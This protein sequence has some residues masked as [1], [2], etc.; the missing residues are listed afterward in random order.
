MRTSYLRYT[1]SFGVA[2]KLFALISILIWNFFFNSHNLPYA[3]QI[4]RTRPTFDQA[5]DC[6][7]VDLLL[8]VNGWEDFCNGN[9]AVLWYCNYKT[10]LG[11]WM[12]RSVTIFQM[13][14]IRRKY[15]YWTVWLHCRGTG[16]CIVQS[17][18]SRQIDKFNKTRKAYKLFWE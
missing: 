8:N 7:D 11:H 13:P 18:R 14:Q 16:V 15:I 6:R 17:G 3:F 5:T 9:I 1:L 10:S 4:A 2:H 12:C